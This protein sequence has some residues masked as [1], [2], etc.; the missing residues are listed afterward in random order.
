[1]RKKLE[2]N[3]LR[4][5]LKHADAEDDAAFL[6]HVAKCRAIALV[7]WQDSYDRLCAAK[8]RAVLE[9]YQT[10]KSLRP[11]MHFFAS[12]G[13][14][15]MDCPRPVCKRARRCAC[16][17]MR[18][19]RHEVLTSAEEVQARADY[20]EFLALMTAPE[21]EEEKASARIASRGGEGASI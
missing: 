5:A 8:G 6:A 21:T 9:A 15:H 3:P 4:A 17:S 14:L 18:C 20:R 10:W 13:V 19:V 12:E 2:R 11:L 1:V 16:G 7:L